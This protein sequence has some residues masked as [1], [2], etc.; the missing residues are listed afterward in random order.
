MRLVF[1]SALALAGC[2]TGPTAQPLARV[3]PAPPPR[4][5]GKPAQGGQGGGAHAAALEQLKSAPLGGRVDKQNSV[6]IK[7]PDPEHWMRVK[8]WGVPSLVGFRYGKDHHAIVAAYVTHVDD[9]TAPNAC[10]KS[11]EAWAKPW[12]DAFDVEIAYE[13]PKAVIWKGMMADINAV[14]AKTATIAARDTY[15]AAYATYPAW[16][17]ACLVFGVAVPARDEVQ[18][19]K[20]VRDRFVRE[21]LPFVE[22]TATEEPKERY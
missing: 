2:S 6:R 18:R 20:D 8:F 14:M 9:N 12:V 7:L 11:F 10:V 5:D 19:A 1:L 16:K 4:D 21:V 13:P 22:V 3:A 17:G 15:A